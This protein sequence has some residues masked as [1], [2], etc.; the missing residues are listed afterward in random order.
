M[1][2]LLPNALFVA[3]VL[4]IGLAAVFAATWYVHSEA[5]SIAS[6]VTAVWFAVLFLCPCN[7][8]RAGRR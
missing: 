2:R 6:G 7:R 1:R 4:A 5:A 8:C 3:E